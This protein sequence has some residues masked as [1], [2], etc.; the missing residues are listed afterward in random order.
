MEKNSSIKA[1]T[2]LAVYWDFFSKFSTQGLQFLFSI[3]L[4][5]LLSPSDYGI[6]ALPMV[7]LA[8]A[9]CFVNSGF[10]AALIRKPEVS[11][12]DLNTAFYFNIIAGLFF[13]VIL[14]WASPFIADFYGVPIL[15]DLFRISALAVILV[16]LQSV[17]YAIL[18][19]KLDYKT[20]A[21]INFFSSIITGVIGIYF[22]YQGYGVWA[23]VIQ[24]VS[25]QLVSTI[26]IWWL[27]K[28][29]PS[30]MWSNASFNY[31]FG[32]GSKILASGL[33]DAVHDNIY[34]IVIG[35]FYSAKDLGLYNRALNYA[36]LP[37]NQINGMLD[38]ISF[39][40]LSKVQSD[41]EKLSQSFLRFLRIN[42]FVLCPI[43]LG[44]SALAYP[45]I[46]VMI[47]EKWVDCVPY[48]QILCIP[49]IFWPIQTLNFTILKVKGRSDIL[50]KMNIG[51]K[52]LGVI[53]M[54][55]ALPF[56]IM[57]MCYGS[58]VHALLGLSWAMYYTSSSTG[59]K[60]KEQLK[61]MVPS[62]TLGIMMFLLICLLNQ[63]I[64]SLLIQLLVGV[65]VGSIFYLSV[66]WYLKYPE[67]K[68]LCYLLH[69]KDSS[70][71]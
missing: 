26:L 63:L 58:I 37:F 36:K 42:I 46:V 30:L 65:L 61:A 28:W 44:L 8:I 60:M 57:V 47:T 32:F 15:N 24:G 45:L 16:P 33:I 54:C 40:V 3:I 53:V 31:L 25:G 64:A 18:A 4:A 51:I 67:I 35:K 10:S 34:P 5:R 56:G 7:F 48:L 11:E 59:I 50:L 20:P 62:V 69:I 21:L 9:Q 17:H 29:R 2:R 43:M 1:Q 68:D 38:S 66:S 14:Y 39:P 71:K 19:R 13:Y 12:Q 52:I 22:A 23:L 41:E 6:I 27:S 70:R 55:C 49:V